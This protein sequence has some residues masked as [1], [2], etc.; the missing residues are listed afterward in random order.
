MALP[1]VGTGF[2]LS[3]GDIPRATAPHAQFS[4]AAFVGCPVRYIG[5]SVPGTTIQPGLFSS[6]GFGFFREIDE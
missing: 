3:P 6:P 1:I 4:R 2:G 5:W